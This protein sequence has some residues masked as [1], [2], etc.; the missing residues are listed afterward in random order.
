VDLIFQFSA[1]TGGCDWVA[2]MKAE[3]VQ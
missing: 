3:A 1:F 2:F